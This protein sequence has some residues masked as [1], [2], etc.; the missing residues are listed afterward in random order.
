MRRVPHAATMAADMTCAPDGA[1]S[2][3]THESR[4]RRES[5]VV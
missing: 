3:R 4:P 5:I 1:D 2:V